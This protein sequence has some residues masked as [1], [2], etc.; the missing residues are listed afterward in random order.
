MNIRGLV[1]AIA[2][3]WA[4]LLLS[5]SAAFATA[6]FASPTGSSLSPCTHAEPCDIMTAINGSKEGDDITIEPG[7]Y[8]PLPAVGQLFPEHPVTIHGQAGASRPV[9]VSAAGTGL[10]A[11]VVLG[12]NTT[13]SDLEIDAPSARYGLEVVVPGV[14]V[15]RV[16]FHV[17]GTESDACFAVSPM[18]MT[19]SVCAADGSTGVGFLLQTNVS[20]TLRNDTFEA[21]GS[22]GIGVWADAL[23]GNRP[24]LTVS[25]A[26]AHGGKADLLASADSNPSSVATIAADHSNYLIATAIPGSGTASVT[27]AGSG[28]N[29][30]APPRFV[31]AG[32]DD[33][34]ELAASPTIGAGFASAV[35]GPLDLD[36][37]P[38]QFGGGVDIGAYQFIPP[39]T[40]PA[41]TP[42]VAVSA[43]GPAAQSGSLA[44]AP[45]DSKPVLSP[46]SFAALPSGPSVASAK[47]TTISYADTQA[48]TTAFVVRKPAGSGVIAHGRCVK[49]PKRHKR[50]SRAKSCTRYTS[51]GSFSHS[52]AIGANR[53]RFSGRV[54]GRALKPGSYQLV[55]APTNAS[56]VTG[57]T[58]INDFKIVG[59]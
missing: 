17:F 44:A 42:P 38:R 59:H 26:I 41:A 27:A 33:F 40:G 16:I 39:P 29:Q 11:I 50:G 22:S 34:H 24:T 43:P 30:T 31:N 52:D 51:L 28:T 58:H 2:V 12:G 32:A 14:N 18:T 7:T 49:A 4:A 47:G 15:D 37:N 1:A 55:S 19:N 57:A 21:P 5:A 9:I 48:A 3:T 45:S 54:S 20:A 53:F 25:N 10:P 8:G 6:R 23:G 46:A 36:G 35:N 13:V 56:G